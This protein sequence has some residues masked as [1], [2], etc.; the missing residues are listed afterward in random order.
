MLINE[1]SASV[2]GVV[3]ACCPSTHRIPSG[4]FCISSTVATNNKK[5][6]STLVQEID[7]CLFKNDLLPVS[8]YNEER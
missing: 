7:V 1:T 6:E 5:K 2:S 4:L 8:A 3:G